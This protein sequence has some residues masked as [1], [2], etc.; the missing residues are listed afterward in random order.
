MLAGV[1][2]GEQ[3]H[4][5]S[6]PGMCHAH[7]L[8]FLTD[9]KLAAR[10]Y[11]AVQSKLASEA[12]DDIVEYVRVV[13]QRVGVK[14]CHDA[15]T[16]QVVDTN[17]DVTDQKRPSLPLPFFETRNSPDN[18][19]GSKP[20]AIPSKGGD[21][22]IRCDEQGKNVETPPALVVNQR[23]AGSSD[24]AD[25]VQDAQ[26]VP[27]LTVDQGF[28]VCVQSS[29]ESEQA[30]MRPRGDDAA[31]PVFYLDNAVTFNS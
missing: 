18:D 9:T 7:D 26:V 4:A 6:F 20:P 31:P 13:S 30:R 3:N 27:R 19:I 10:Q 17:L 11:I 16:S 28:S 29:M 21:G 8:N 2:L 14:G 24:S 15:A 1:L 23:R 12:L 25:G 22:P 5:V